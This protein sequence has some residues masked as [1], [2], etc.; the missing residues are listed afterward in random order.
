MN[1]SISQDELFNNVI[2][3]YRNDDVIMEKYLSL[4]SGNSCCLYDRLVR[5]KLFKNK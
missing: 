4:I 5:Y 2:S 1:I 3:F